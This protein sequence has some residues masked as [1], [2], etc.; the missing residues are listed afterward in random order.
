MYCYRNAQ[1]VT[2]GGFGSASVL[3]QSRSHKPS[4]FRSDEGRSTDAASESQPESWNVDKRL[5]TTGAGGGNRK[6]M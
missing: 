2:Y 6:R 1:I 5:G 4:L 3:P